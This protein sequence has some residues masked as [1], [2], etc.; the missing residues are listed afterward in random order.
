MPSPAQKHFARVRTAREAATAS[1]GEAMPANATQYELHL[2][3]L[4]QDMR[5][6]KALQSTEA[7]IKVK[8]ELL[9]E[10]IPYVTGAL[11]S[12]NGAQDDVLMSVMVWRIDAGD[13][14]GALDIATYALRHG[15]TLPERYKRTPACLIAEEIAEEAMQAIAAD[16]S[17]DIDALRRTA[18]LTADSDMP[19]EVRAKLQKAM[20]LALAEAAPADALGHLKRA[21]ELH[22]RCG[23]KKQIEQLERTLRNASSANADT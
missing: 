9:P 18:D 3:K 10:Y 13:I 20:G 12:G 15:L 16:K 7:K 1:P 17:P 2:S 11:E 8:R 14:D 22:S 4:G 21:L 6:L 5:R 23:V 19:D